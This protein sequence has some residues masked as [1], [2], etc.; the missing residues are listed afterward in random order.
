[1]SV[2]YFALLGLYINFPLDVSTLQ[3]SIILWVA[4]PVLLGPF[5]DKW[6]KVMLMN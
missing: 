4:K 3:D 6:D 1:M 2:F 5:K